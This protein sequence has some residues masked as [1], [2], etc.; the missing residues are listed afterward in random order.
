MFHLCF[1]RALHHEDDED[2]ENSFINVL[3]DLE[4][5]RHRLEQS[6][7]RMHF[8]RPN[9]LH[10]LRRR[11]SSR[12]VVTDG[13]LITNSMLDNSNVNIPEPISDDSV[14]VVDVSILNFLCMF[15]TNIT[16]VLSV[17]V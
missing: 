12:A 16:F 14:L 13:P 8:M 2:S 1:F 7:E 9:L 6:R 11:R 15:N 4:Q 17:A 3:S 10:R 5:F